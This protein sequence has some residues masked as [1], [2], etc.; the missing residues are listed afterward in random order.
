M[1]TGTTNK[2]R[3]NELRKYVTTGT[4]LDRYI[5]SSSSSNDGVNVDESQVSSFPYKIRYY[6]GGIKYTDKIQSNG[7]TVTKFSYTPKGT[8][9]KNFIDEPI[10]KNPSKDNIIGNPKIID[11]V[12]ID[13]GTQSAF[14][15]N[16]R[17]KYMTNLNDILTYAGGRYFNIINN[18]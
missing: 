4:L 2:S 3:L 9:S 1:A 8:D 6:I 18:T 13:R 7:D 10:I 14:E 16:Y 17:L 15:N 12:F 5:H 11:D